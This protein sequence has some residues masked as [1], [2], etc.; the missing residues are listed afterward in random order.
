MIQNIYDIECS[1]WNKQRAFTSVT[2]SMDVFDAWLVC[3]DVRLGDFSTR[4]L[5]YHKHFYCSLPEK[6]PL[7]RS[8]KTIN[9]LLKALFAVWTDS[10]TR[11]D[12]L[13]IQGWAVHLFLQEI[14][15][16]LI[17]FHLCKCKE[18]L[19]QWCHFLFIMEYNS[20]TPETKIQIALHTALF[21]ISS[22]L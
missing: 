22:Q 20:T 15:L 8:S 3:D 14:L 1:S 4:H 9:H 6:Q 2:K 18:I 5:L 16:G 7:S 19:H 12:V 13:H 10:S 21:Y 11:K 17:L